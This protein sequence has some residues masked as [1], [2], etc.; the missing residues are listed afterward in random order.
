MTDTRLQG[1]RWIRPGGDSPGEPVPPADATRSFLGRSG[2]RLARLIWLATGF[3]ALGLGLA[4]VFL[5]LLPTTPFVLLAAACFARS[6]TRFHTWLLDHRLAGP[7]IREWQLHRAMPRRA[8]RVAYGLLLLSFGSSMLLVDAD[9]HRL[10]LAALGIS[11][12][13]FLWRVPVR[14]APDQPASDR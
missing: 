8:K 3:L 5:P 6:S 4:G 9:W 11:L 1:S 10:L 2:K 7:V 12:G 14:D 13:Y